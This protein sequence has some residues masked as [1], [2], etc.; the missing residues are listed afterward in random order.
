MFLD[1]LF[2][3]LDRGQVVPV[4]DSPWMIGLRAMPVP[5]ADYYERT[6]VYTGVTSATYTNGYV[7]T[8]T[9]SGSEG[10]YTYA[11]TC[12][13]T[14]AV[15]TA[16]DT[17]PIMDGTGAAGDLATY[18]R[19]NH[20][21]P[22]DTSR[23]TQVQFVE[24]TG[25]GI[26]SGLDTT[27]QDTP[28]MTVAVSDGI[29]YLSDGT[30]QAVT[31]NAALA[32]DTPDAAKDRIDLIYVD[33]DGV[34][35]YIAGD[36]DI[37]AV[38]GARSYTFTV[39]AAEDDTLAL[40]GETFTAIRTTPS[41]DE[42][43]IGATLALTAT[44]IYN[45]LILNTDITDL[46]D[47]TNPSDGVITITEKVAG[48]GNTPGAIACVGS[49]DITSGTP[50][51]SAA[52]VAGTMTYTITDRAELADTFGVYGETMTCVNG[53]PGADEFA[54]AG[55]I[56]QTAIN[57]AAALA[58]NANIAADF[59]VTN[60][61]AGVIVLTEK[62]PGGG[63]SPGASSTTG[64]LAVTDSEGATS[65]AAVAGVRSYTVVGQAEHKDTLQFAEE[66]FTALK[67]AAGTDE[68]DLCVDTTALATA[69]YNLINA[70]AVLSA[71]Y[72][73][74]NPSAGVVTV[75]ET[76]P[77]GLD[78]PGEMTPTGTVEV[79]NGSAT[80]SV[81]AVSAGTVP[82]T[83]A[84]GIA[85]AELDIDHTD[86]DVQTSSITKKRVWTSPGVND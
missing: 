39:N 26:H 58:A 35:R 10:A 48:G 53:V 12:I 57:L 7:Y 81:A 17:T 67:A 44:A 47:V 60:P 5:S 62:V 76:T 34:L 73:A 40:D 75:T 18:S 69:I 32:V 9:R 22:S 49:I 29:R 2:R 11:W 36:I 55:T 31:G 71:I 8:C 52:V 59:D 61:S 4:K 46:Y 45:A 30:R 20:V 33:A 85:I 68:F 72:T 78:T 54:E 13:S 64:T 79:T 14:D 24:K 43:N 37:D 84:G 65:A 25:Y 23:A 41:T 80:A 83:P 21:H 66:I 74:T 16:S 56:A 77:G 19:G 51:A 3:I 82:A 70:N 50:T 6:V 27:Q 15:R 38:A 28:D 63:D 42:Y 86:S 1:A